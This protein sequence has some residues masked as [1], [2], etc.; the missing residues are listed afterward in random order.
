LTAYPLPGGSLSPT[1]AR[2]HLAVRLPR[3]AR[4]RLRGSRL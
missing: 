3:G 4:G 2:D 1:P